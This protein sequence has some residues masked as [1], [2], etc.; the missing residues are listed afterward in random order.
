MTV[1]TETLAAL[2]GIVVAVGV[3]AVLLVP[4]LIKRK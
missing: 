2:P 3:F 1:L 4:L